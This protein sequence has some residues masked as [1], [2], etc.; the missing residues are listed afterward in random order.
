MKMKCIVCGAEAD[1][2]SFCDECW[3]KGKPLFEIRDFDLKVCECGSC[4]REGRWVR[5]TDFDAMAR[6][7]IKERIKAF[8]RISGME[9]SIRRIGNKAQAS[10]NS[11]GF[12]APCKSSKKEGHVININIR[13]VKCEDCQKE[14]A[15]YYEAVIQL[16]AGNCLD[17]ILDM[18]GESVLSVREVRG[19]YD[20]ILRKNEVAK[21]ITGKLM[22]EGMKVIRS[23]DYLAQK[24][25]KKIYRNYYSVKSG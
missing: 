11:E 10:V 18:G 1:I 15:S 20:I 12:I 6:D 23:A 5:F 24:N 13:R 9:I 2:E 3:L 7:A 16:R 21:Q 25:N 22:K 19:G 4:F 17:R 14:C 8:G